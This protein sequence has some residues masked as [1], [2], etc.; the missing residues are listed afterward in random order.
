MEK[1]VSIPHVDPIGGSDT[2]VSEPTFIPNPD[3][4][5]P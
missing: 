2:V 1:I 4:V 5:L 3:L